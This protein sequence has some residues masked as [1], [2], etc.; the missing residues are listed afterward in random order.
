[1]NMTNVI[2]AFISCDISCFG[3]QLPVVDGV[4]ATA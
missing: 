1:M 2:G 3:I 4:E